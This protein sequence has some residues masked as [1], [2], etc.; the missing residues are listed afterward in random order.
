M[1]DDQLVQRGMQGDGEAFSHLF[2]RYH[3][4]VC[5]IIYPIVRNQ[6]DMEDVAG[7][8]WKKVWETLSTL[9]DRSR[10][11]PW[12]TTIAKNTARDHLRRDRWRNEG[13]NE[14]DEELV[15]PEDIEDQIITQIE[16]EEA[17]EAAFKKMGYKRRMCF[18]YRIQGWTVKDIAKELHLAEGTVRTYICDAYQIIREELHKRLDGDQ[19]AE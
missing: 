9:R 6:Q 17:Q 18:T 10:F 1:D 5:K 16:F 7:S 15:G 13:S 19:N 14:E 11:K 12:L 2:H 4:L 8:T 3:R